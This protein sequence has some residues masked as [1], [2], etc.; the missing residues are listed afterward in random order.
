MCIYLIKGLY[1]LLIW[2]VV[3]ACDK[4]CMSKKSEVTHWQLNIIL[5]AVIIIWAL[6]PFLNI[7][8]LFSRL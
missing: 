8:A 6:L 5:I 4:N 2:Q 7:P 1:L 3:M